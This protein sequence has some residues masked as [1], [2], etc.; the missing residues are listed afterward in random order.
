MTSCDLV[1]LGCALSGS[2][3]AKS[4]HVTISTVD[5]ED[6]LE[7][8]P[9]NQREK[10]RELVGEIRTLVPTDFAPCLDLGCDG[11]N[12]RIDFEDG[13]TG[14]SA[15]QRHFVS[16]KGM[17]K[18]LKRIE[19]DDIRTRCIEMSG[20]FEEMLSKA[21][22]RPPKIPSS[23]AAA[24]QFREELEIRIA[25]VRA[26]KPLPAFALIVGRDDCGVAI[27]ETL[28]SRDEVISLIADR[29]TTECDILAVLERGVAWTF[30]EIEEAKLAALEELGP[31]SRAK[32]ERRFF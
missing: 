23:Q 14:C 31:I 24:E 11:L 29:M 6:G 5:V 25:E 28:A 16:S 15:F 10:V 30:P 19:W 17:R 20:A 1:R 8:I 18:T 22:D 7:V 4:G 12:L 9:S 27:E 26:K 21:D 3:A 32:A 2:S 13:N